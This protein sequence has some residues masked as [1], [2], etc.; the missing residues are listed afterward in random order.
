MLFVI[1][2]TCKQ[3]KFSSTSKWIYTLHYIHQ[4][5]K[6]LITKMDQCLKHATPWTNFQCTVVNE[7]SQ[8]KRATYI[9][10]L[11]IKHL[12]K[13]KYEHR[14]QSSGCQGCVCTEGLFVKGHIGFLAKKP[15]NI[16][17]LVV[18]T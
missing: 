5:E 6:Y 16:F 13:A 12:A 2:Q 17:T 1:S 11:F 4:I 3:L 15:L 14:K 7:I 10:I 18:V 8:L 9:M